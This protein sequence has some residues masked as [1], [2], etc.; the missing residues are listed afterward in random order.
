M[1]EKTNT[2]KTI[3]FSGDSIV[4]GF[5]F[6]RTQSF[7][8]IIERD[9]G[10]T[11]YNEGSN[12]ETAAYL[13]RYFAREVKRLKPDMVFIMTGS[14]DAEEPGADASAIAKL[15]I[16]MA[17]QASKLGTTPVILTPIDMD[18]E[19]ARARWAHGVDFEHCNR[20]LAEIGEILKASDHQ[21]I[22]T[23]T[24]YRE[25]GEYYDGVHPTPA[26]YRFIADI[27]IN[28]NII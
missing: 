6:R 8:A 26:G 23:G 9:L 25:C 27:I 15:I 1:S 17:D 5:P 11:V 4:N 24:L 21:V 14:N 19:M 20:I 10:V 3:L 12:G 18:P 7:P 2:T 28:S 16:G 22:D 13:S